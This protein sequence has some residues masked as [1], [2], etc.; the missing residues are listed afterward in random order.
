M[1]LGGW[2][3]L[4]LLGSL[5]ISPH[6]LGHLWSAFSS[7]IPHSLLVLCTWRCIYTSSFFTV[8][9]GRTRN[10]GGKTA[11]VPKVLSSGGLWETS[12]RSSVSPL[13][14]PDS[15][16]KH[17]SPFRSPTGVSLCL[18]WNWSWQKRA[19]VHAAP[20]CQEHRNF[21]TREGQSWPVHRALLSGGSFPLWFQGCP[22]QPL[23]VS[24]IGEASWLQRNSFFPEVGSTQGWP[25]LLIARQKPG[26]H[27]SNSYR[28]C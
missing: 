4:G 22:T 17:V 11:C 28:S 3:C 7:R 5:L 25:H 21:P 14:L 20:S 6:S 19:K 24:F 10:P 1:N 13:W 2:N 12:P 23:W 8:L 9:K 27:S 16:S 18:W 26:K 15:E